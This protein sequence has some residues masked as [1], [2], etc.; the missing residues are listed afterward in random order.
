MDIKKKKR[1]V[2]RIVLV[3][4]N[5]VEEDIRPIKVRTKLIR[6]IFVIF[7]LF[8]G[9]ALGYYVF[10]AQIISAMQ[11][12]QSALADII[13]EQNNTIEA[14]NTE[15]EQLSNQIEELNRSL[16]ILSDTVLQKAQNEQELSEQI[17]EQSIPTLFPIST[18]SVLTE[19]KE[20]VLDINGEV[21]YSA[22]V[23]VLMSQINTLVMS[24]GAG[25]VEEI[26]EEP[27]YGYSLTVNHNNGYKT[28]YRCNGVVTVSAGQKVNPGDTLFLITEDSEPIGYQL[29][30]EG[31]FINPIEL[32]D[33]RG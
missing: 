8:V 30:Y 15:K 33:I 31:V 4:T 19:E 22:P 28:V 16:Q 2:N 14:L 13:I 21:E 11:S 18:S 5:N 32:M 23:C 29:M 7:C 26:K 10:E 17:A 6:A 9:A 1:K 20:D 12:K 3:A 24:T 27:K 25:V